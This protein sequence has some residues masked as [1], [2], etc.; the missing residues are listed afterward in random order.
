M[1][2]KDI[3][4]L[5]KAFEQEISKL[6]LKKH[7]TEADMTHLGDSIK[8]L[9]KQQTELN[10]KMAELLSAN[11]SV[12]SK[13]MHIKDNLGKLTS[14]LEKLKILYADLKEV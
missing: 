8:V 14:K 1:V 9:E 5:F 4:N 3:E 2:K 7:E 10:K 11:T 6:E 13:R 12:S